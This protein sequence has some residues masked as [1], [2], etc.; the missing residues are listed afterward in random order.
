MIYNNNNNSSKGAGA[1]LAEAWQVYAKSFGFI[2]VLVLLTFVPVFLFRMFLPE[3][4]Y[5]AYQDYMYTFQ[6]FLDGR[7]DVSLLALSLSDGAFIY[8]AM[9]FGI[10]LVFFPLLAAGA[11]YLVASRMD[12]KPPS[13]DAMFAAIFPQFP[14]I[15]VT[16]AL[17]TALLFFLTYFLAGFLN[18]ILLIIPIYIGITY[19]FFMQVTANTGRWGLGALSMSRFLVRGR[20]FKTFIP[21]L[22]LGIFFLIS[23]VA[24]EILSSSIIANLELDRLFAL[25]IFL[26]GQMLLA[27]FPLIFAVWYFDIR[28]IKHADLQALEKMLFDTINEAMERMRGGGWTGRPPQEPT[29]EDRDESTEN[30][31]NKP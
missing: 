31:N 27:I 12:N 30:D 23:S 3:H 25:P 4:Y 22:F 15:I 24:L 10:A 9:H 18:G 14:K 6:A 11:V 19:V 13:F 29:D 21:A 16:T 17:V 2:A 8:A 28:R 5:A 1:I 7:A 20:W 26:I